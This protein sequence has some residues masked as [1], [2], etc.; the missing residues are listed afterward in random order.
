MSGW[1]EQRLSLATWCKPEDVM[2]DVIEAAVVHRLRPP[3][4]IDKVG[5]S[6]GRLREARTRMANIARAW[7]P[8]IGSGQ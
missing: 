1:M 4:N 8:G 2:L 6:K 5:E 3:L 7:Q